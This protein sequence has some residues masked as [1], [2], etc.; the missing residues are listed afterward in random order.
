MDLK[1]V[2]L[3]PQVITMILHCYFEDNVLQNICSKIALRKAAHG[4][5]LL[6][7][8]SVNFHFVPGQ[9]VNS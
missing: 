4:T 2:Q 6:T 7:N 3:G 1:T 9:I 8:S 5:T